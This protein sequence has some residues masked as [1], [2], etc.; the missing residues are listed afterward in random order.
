MIESLKEKIMEPMLPSHIINFIISVLFMSF[1]IG[2]RTRNDDKCGFDKSED[3]C[4]Y[5]V[6]SGVFGLLFSASF[7]VCEVTWERIPH[8]HKKIYYSQMFIGA[9]LSLSFIISFFSMVTK[10]ISTESDVSRFVSHTNIYL[11]IIFSL[12]GSFTWAGL[13]YLSYLAKKGNEFSASSTSE[14]NPLTSLNMGG[15]ERLTYRDPVTSSYQ[16][17]RNI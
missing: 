12:V 17:P 14:I 9:F 5:S 2:S 10:W 15:I 4:S 11:S 1:V 16:A 8:C 7:I 6:S 13:S 3:V